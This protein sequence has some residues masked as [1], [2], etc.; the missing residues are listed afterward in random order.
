MLDK[1]ITLE[2]DGWLHCD[3]LSKGVLGWGVSEGE[4]IRGI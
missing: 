2:T 1:T 4:S 3:E